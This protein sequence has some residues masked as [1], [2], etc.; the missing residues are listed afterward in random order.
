MWND[1]NFIF[2]II[3]DDVVEYLS[4]R[5]A[6]LKKQGRR[7]EP[8]LTV[9]WNIT[10]QNLHSVQLF[11][12][13]KRVNSQCFFFYFWSLLRSNRPSKPLK[14]TSILFCVIILNDTR[15]F[16]ASFAV[17]CCLIWCAG[18][19]QSF[20]RSIMNVNPI[21]GVHSSQKKNSK[22]PLKFPLRRGESEDPQHNRALIK[23]TV[24]LFHSAVNLFDYLYLYTEIP[25]IPT[26]ILTRC[27]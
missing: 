22:P 4:I 14:M 20:L 21:Y 12:N 23:W 6:Q 16:S 15:F 19:P 9:G 25:Q 5:C 24:S 10:T 11:T 17:H 18:V 2:F 13:T 7:T 27:L 26:V 8:I 3:F 1:H